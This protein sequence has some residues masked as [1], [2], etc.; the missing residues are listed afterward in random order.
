MDPE[1]GSGSGSGSWV[2]G[3]GN[4]VGNDGDGM[5]RYAGYRGELRSLELE[6]GAEGAGGGEH[7]RV[8]LDTYPPCAGERRRENTSKCI[9][10]G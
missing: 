9:I 10:H 5:P 7:E 3:L 6:A 1:A 8:K 2:L 4:N